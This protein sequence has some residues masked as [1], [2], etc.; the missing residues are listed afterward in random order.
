MVTICISLFTMAWAYARK[1][2]MKRSKGKGNQ[3][4]V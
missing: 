1:K 3:D 2:I 4:V